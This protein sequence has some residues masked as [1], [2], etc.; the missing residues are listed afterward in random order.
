MDYKITEKFQTLDLDELLQLRDDIVEI[1]QSGDHSASEIVSERFK[2][3]G[4]SPSMYGSIDRLF[5]KVNNLNIP[6]KHS[7]LINELKE[8][9][10]SFKKGKTDPLEGN[11]ALNQFIGLLD[12]KRIKS[13]FYRS[14]FND[15]KCH[16]FRKAK[17]PSDSPLSNLYLYDS[18]IN[19]SLLYCPGR[20]PDK[21]EEQ[22]NDMMHKFQ[23][24]Y[25]HIIDGHNKKHFDEKQE[26]L[27]ITS[28]HLIEEASHSF[29]VNRVEII[30]RDFIIS[31]ELE[32][33][34]HYNEIQGNSEAMITYR[35]PVSDPTKL[36][37]LKTIQ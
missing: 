20:D 23:Q 28:S 36:K 18:S 17:E 7:G 16:L 32:L 1:I 24:N 4:N 2:L 27:S 10:S 8:Q 9:Y 3:L 26:I 33:E 12:C 19:I 35:S 13:D 37:L 29:S 30:R 5:D 25:S 22:Y 34:M 14:T 11:D 21:L 15:L 31:H 6:E